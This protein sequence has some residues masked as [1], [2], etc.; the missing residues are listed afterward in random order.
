MEPK[1]WI[2]KVQNKNVAFLYMRGL[3]Y[4]LKDKVFS[5]GTTAKNKF[6]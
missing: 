1:P 5:L 6:Q 3:S 4:S 2:G